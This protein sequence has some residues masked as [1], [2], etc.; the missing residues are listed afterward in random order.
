MKKRVLVVDDDESVRES[1]S[2]VLR[3]AGYE[4]RQAADGDEA[5]KQFDPVQIDLLL[6]DIGLPVRNGWDTFERITSL[7][8][9][10]PVII[11]TGQ[12]G[13]QKIARAAGVGALMEKPLDALRLLQTIQ[14][15]LAEPKESRLQ[16]FIGYDRE[17]R[18]VPA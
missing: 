1:L 10:L 14:D 9:Q 7:D 12:T 18:H 13:Q 3:E 6:L 15:L 16:R 17:I 5:L 8:P 2:K 11:V 4:V